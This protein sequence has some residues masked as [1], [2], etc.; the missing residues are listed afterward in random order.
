MSSVSDL[1]NA[2]LATAEE[3]FSEIGLARTGLGHA[4]FAQKDEDCLKMAQVSF[5]DRSHASRFNANT[6][7]FGIELGVFY[8]FIPRSNGTT[9]SIENLPAIFECH[10][11]GRLLKN[12]KQ[13]APPSGNSENDSRRDIWWV[14]TSGKNLAPVTASLR[15]VI[16]RKAP[17]WL[18]RFSNLRFAYWYLHWFP[19]VR[20]SAPINIGRRGCPYRTQLIAS[21][22][23]RLGSKWPL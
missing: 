10:L 19:A 20:P 4:T 23:Q 18:K 1:I 2:I 17:P 16:K 14:E 15:S 5:L 11:R 6:A 22:D 9:A 13:V 8:R 12:I 7:C 21:I 3:E